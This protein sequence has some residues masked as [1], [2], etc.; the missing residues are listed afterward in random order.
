MEWISASQ[1][2]SREAAHALGQRLL[3]FH[4]VHHVSYAS[5]QLKERELYRLQEVGEGACC[6]PRDLDLEE[7]AWAMLCG[8][9][10]VALSE[11]P[12][13]LHLNP[14]HWVAPRQPCLQARDALSWL[15]AR[16]RIN[17][18]TAIALGRRLVLRGF[19]APYHHSYPFADED[20]LFVPVRRPPLALGPR[21]PA[22]RVLAVLA[23]MRAEDTYPG[24]PRDLD[25]VIEALA[26]PEGPLRLH[27][28]ELPLPLD[29]AADPETRNFLLG[30]LR[31]IAWPAAVVVPAASTSVAASPRGGGGILSGAATASAGLSPL[32]PPQQLCAHSL[33]SSREAPAGQTSGGGGGNADGTVLQ[34]DL[35][36]GRVPLLAMTGATG[37]A[38][39]AFEP[40]ARLLEELPGRMAEWNFPV[41]ELEERSGGH[42]LF[43]V[44]WSV[45]ESHRL[46]E[47]LGFDRRALKALLLSLEAGYRS[48]PYHNATH[49][50]DVAQTL[51]FLLVRGG[52]A[53]ELSL[54]ELLGALLAAL[55]HDLNHPGVNNA[56]LIAVHSPLAL[57]YNDASPLENYHCSEFFKLLLQQPAV[58]PLLRPLG[59]PGLRELRELIIRLVL[60]TDFAQHMSFLG[61]FKSR[62]LLG[63]ELSK[64][65][66][67]LLLLQ[68]ALKCA[69]ISHTAKAPELHLAWTER[70]GREFF[71]QGEREAALGLPVSPGFDRATADVPRLQC[72][73]ISFCARP[74]F[75]AFAEQ[76]PALDLVLEQLDANL[77]HWE[78]LRSPTL[79]RSP[80]VRSRSFLLHYSPSLAP[81]FFFFGLFH[82]L[83]N[84]TKR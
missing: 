78:A 64:P 16:L 52:L 10:G 20:F 33:K 36:Q 48:N 43:Y 38:V 67:R 9:D 11:P 37:A 14:A 23:R 71:A 55:A 68:A 29:P 6:A 51:N 35:V 73:F 82:N 13:L 47:R 72:G 56:F 19:L 75:E 32:L 24:D 77:R 18:P 25:F 27:D 39:D 57:Q 84:L 62:A 70:I 49:A 17:R 81:F 65:A 60:A 2:V 83:T 7:L 76:F 54:L 50:A 80:E 46:P 42:A 34:G 22:E 45:L 79:P 41:F 8:P 53:R 63:F 40:D 26:S 59:R 28:P 3:D 44:G 69:D 58:A 4:Y 15:Q 61:Q 21:F 74:L 1:K 12:K 66:D 31:G 30:H 5:E